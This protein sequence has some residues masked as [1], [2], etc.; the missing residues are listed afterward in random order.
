MTAEPTPA[1][2]SGS[3]KA[4]PPPHPVSSGRPKVRP[5]V[6]RPP[7]AAA[8]LA[9]FAPHKVASDSAVCWC[10]EV[11]E[12]CIEMLVASARHQ[13]AAF[14]FVAGLRDILRAADPSVR[15][16]AARRALLLVDME[17]RNPE[18][19]QAARSHP[20][21]PLRVPAWR[22]SFGRPAA[23]PLARS[24]LILAWSSVR[25]APAVARM[26][27]GI[28]DPVSEIIASLKMEQIEQIAQSR[29]QHVRPRW[30]DRPAVWR[31]LFL[32]AQADDPELML[33]FN[34]HALQLLAGELLP[35]A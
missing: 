27:L 5:R 33:E 2:S 8:D 29:H 26:L 32:A 6:S 13:E 23:I 19:W 25:S 24:T 7:R 14:P 17:F 35:R 12:R 10:L 30:D 3:R 20:N 18:W 1:T 34:L 28:A 31:K 16:R 4:R 11:N 21:Q 22:G 9:A 15:K